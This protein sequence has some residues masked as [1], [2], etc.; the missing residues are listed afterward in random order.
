MLCLPL[1]ESRPPSKAAAAPG[2]AVGA[3]GGGPGAGG[4]RSAPGRRQGP[5]KPFRAED[6]GKLYPLPSA[7]RRGVELLLAIYGAAGAELL[8]PA[9]PVATS[10]AT[11]CSRD[12]RGR[13]V[14]AS[15]GP[16]NTA[17]GSPARICR[18]SPCSMKPAR[19]PRSHAA[20]PALGR[21]TAPVG[22]G[23][24]A[25]HFRARENARAER[26]RPAT[27]VNAL[28]PACRRGQQPEWGETR[29]GSMR[30]TTAR[31]PQHA[32]L[33][34]WPRSLQG[35]SQAQLAIFGQLKTVDNK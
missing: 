34:A 19:R 1:V 16:W 17:A 4:E 27:A 14:G 7:P 11:I 13:L 35:R 25:L 15:K 24:A 23:P 8:L 22:D 20:T 2:G 5:S 9:R 18:E 30:S 12:Q 31:P 33:N 10:W 21:I 28:E 29:S 3:G 6:R 26:C 32:P